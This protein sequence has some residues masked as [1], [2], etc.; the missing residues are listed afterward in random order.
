VPSDLGM[1]AFNALMGA[2][3]LAMDF[4]TG[5]AVNGRWPATATSV[6]NTWANVVT[7]QPIDFVILADQSGSMSG[8]KWASLK[9]AGDNFALVLSKVKDNIDAEYTG[10]GVTGGGDR[11]GL[12]NFTWTGG[13]DH[14]STV[15]PL[16]AIPASPGGFT[17]GL[18]ASPGGSTPIAGG[19]NRTFVMFNNAPTFGG[20]P[21][22]RVVMLMSDGMHNEPSTTIDFATQGVSLNYLP[23]PCGNNSL[24][25]VNT[26]AV[27]SDA[28][29]DVSKLNQIKSCYAGST[30]LKPDGATV[31]T[32]NTADPAEGQLTAQLTKYFVQTL[33]P[34]YH[35]NTIN[36]TGADFTINAGDRRVLLFAFWDN[37][38]D[39]VNLTVTKPDMSIATGSSNTSLGYSWLVLDNPANGTYT[40]FTA[41]GA[42]AKFA[43]V[44]LRVRGDFAIDNQVHGTGGTILLRAKLQER[45]QTV[46][47]AQVRVDMRRPGEGFGTYV[48]TH[49]LADCSVRAPSLPP[50]AQETGVLAAPV[51]RGTQPAAAGDVQVP[52]FALLAALFQKCGKSSLARV[53]NPGLQLVDDGSHGDETPNDGVSV[54]YKQLRA[55]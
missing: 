12:A 21:R 10:I 25:R 40:G 6:P 1:N 15:V 36:T 26:I 22:T 47:G 31:N 51:A 38:A 33:L 13:A 50:F 30:F 55:H 43:F 32:Y 35:W 44:D 4:N 7:R 46:T 48:S 45:G 23:S 14:S 11:L 20:L 54:S 18:P 27:G 16:A 41:T 37:K 3:T 17:G 2:A 34:Y 52:R 5:A 19:L 28:T 29:V 9:R 42:S 39:A 49:S 24:V 8:A 53:T